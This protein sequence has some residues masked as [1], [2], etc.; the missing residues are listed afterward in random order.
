MMNKEINDSKTL[1]LLEKLYGMVPDC[2]PCISGCNKCCGPVMML[3][4]EARRLGLSEPITPT[5][6]NMKC[7]FSVGGRC[8]VY[9]KRPFT[10]RVFN[11]TPSCPMNCPEMKDH[12]SLPIEQVNMMFTLYFGMIDNEDDMI[13]LER[14]M[15]NHAP[16]CYAHDKNNGWIK[17]DD[18]AID[19]KP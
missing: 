17:E 14:A 8:S 18:N 3:P 5:D 10:C 7:L 13:E 11:A 15:K 9:D 6:E 4:V 19:R 2:P 1:G 16:R 12:G